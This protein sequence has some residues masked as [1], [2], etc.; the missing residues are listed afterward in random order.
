VLWYLASPHFVSPFFDKN[1]RTQKTAETLSPQYH[2]C[3]HSLL[4]LTCVKEDEH[5]VRVVNHK[6]W[7][8]FFGGIF[9]CALLQK[10]WQS[11]WI[12][13]SFWVEPFIADILGGSL[14]IDREETCSIC[15]ACEVDTMFIPCKH[16]SCQRCI[17]R[18]LLNNQ[19]CFFCN[20][21]ISELCSMLPP[22]TTPLCAAGV[23]SQC[24]A[25]ADSNGTLTR[26][27]T[28][29]DLQS[30]SSRGSLSRLHNI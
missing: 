6:H 10:A 2:H 25:A 13:L 14:A 16:Q 3:I 4:F 1:P 24:P 5:G 11:V 27:T 23:N 15:Y 17:S 20:S 18:H 7:S 9:F 8:Y 22:T 26:S 29:H 21:T 12:Y 30:H 19:R 28:G